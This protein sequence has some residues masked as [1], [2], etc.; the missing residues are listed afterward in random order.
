MLERLQDAGLKLK[1]E[2]CAFFRKEVL[3]L[4]HVVSEDGIV[5]DSTKTDKVSN[6][7]TPS[8]VPQLQAFL[9]LA[10]YYRHFIQNFSELAKPLHEL[11]G[12]DKT[13]QWTEQCNRAFQVLKQQLTTTPILAYPDFTLPFILDTDASNHSLGAVL[14]QE[15]EGKERVVCYDSKLLS[16]EEQSYCVTRK[17]LLAVVTFVTKFR[18]YL[19]GRHFYVRTDHGALVWLQN[20]KEPEGQLARWLEKL[21]EFNYTI[22]HRRGHTHANA[23]ALSR[24][25]CNQRRCPVHSVEGTIG[26]IALGSEADNIRELQLNDPDIGQVIRGIGSGVPK[27]DPEHVK[28]L[29]PTMR[30][31]IQQ[32]EQLLVKDH[33]LYRKYESPDGATC[34]LQLVVP[35]PMRSSILHQLHEAPAGG[36]LGEDKTLHKLRERFYW[37]GHQKDVKIWCRTCK[38]CAARKTP[39]PKRKASLTPIKVGYPLQMIGIDFLGPLVETDAG[40]R[41]VLVVGDHFTKYMS[42]FAVA[43]QEAETVANVL[44]EE[45]FCDKGFP[46]QLH[47]DQGAQ[48]ESQLIAE[49]CKA[50]EI[51]K[52]RTTAYHPACNGEI[53]RFNKTL[54]DMLA[55]ALEGHHF[56][57]DK[58]LKMACF[59]YNT[60]VHATTG[61]TPFYL[62]HGYEA[63][64]PVDVVYGSAPQKSTSSHDYVADM[65]Q[66]ITTAFEKVRE[67]TGQEQLRQKQY[68]DQKVHGAP[69]QVGD[70]VWLWQPAVPRK[71]RYCAKFHRAWQGPHVIVKRISDSTYRIK[72]SKNKRL[73]QVVHFDRL[74]PCNPG[75]RIENEAQ[76]Q[77]APSSEHPSQIPI[78]IDDV[79]A[80]DKPCVIDATEDDD[81]EGDSHQVV[82]EMATPNLPQNDRVAEVDEVETH[83]QGTETV[84]GDIGSQ[85]E[86]D[87]AEPDH[88]PA[89]DVTGSK[90]YPT[91]QRQEPDRYG[92]YICH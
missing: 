50:M 57:W 21:Q 3:Y 42:A 37:P 35:A 44:M 19:L 32:W 84:A 9:G 67:R 62:M 89:S 53:E 58:Q 71:R 43:N 82:N 8:C 16:K 2:K 26:V 28:P 34:K 46:E 47:S 45:Y 64:L 33:I 11:I 25:S 39:V 81:F 60:S 38:D 41:Y 74:K 5:P 69:F 18:S 52:T 77:P 63:R 68:Y 24:M 29:G 36:H 20:F 59:A 48:F 55:T 66:R 88:M 22:I 56:D 14:S 78:G 80:V 70:L 31:L 10:N 1:P 27:P 90:R 85:S 13:F 6:W 49:M 61:Y 40:N 83:H 91:R 54:A 12:K 7:P 15:H 51:R 87:T 30:A 75:I 65:H 72:S 92:H 73:R 86:F 23:D 79:P 4:G 17:E 76:Q